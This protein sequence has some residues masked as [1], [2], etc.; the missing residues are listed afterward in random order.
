MKFANLNTITCYSMLNSTIKIPDLVQTAKNRGYSSLAIT[1]YNV[2]HGAIQFYDQCLANDLKPII[3]MTLQTK[4]FKG[5]DVSVVLLAQNQ[6]GY[7][8]L[9]KISTLIN[10]EQIGFDLTKFK[11][12]IAGITAIIH[13]LEN[14]IFQNN[15]E[16]T[17]AL[18]TKYQ[19]IFSTLYLGYC[20][21]VTTL[22]TLEIYEKIY[23]EQK[24]KIVYLADVRYL[25]AEDAVALKVLRA[26]DEQAI[27]NPADPLLSAPGIQ[28]LK[29]VKEITN[30]KQGDLFEA[31]ANAN[32][33]A[34][35]LNV[36]ITKEKT[37]LPHFKSTLKESNEYLA[38]LV[39]DGLKKIGK[40]QDSHY[41]KRANNELKVIE[42]MGFA[43][44]FL[45]IWDIVNYAN[46]AQIQLGAGRG[47]AAGSLV[48][49]ALGISKVDPI[50]YGLFFER[51]LNPERVNMPDIDLDVPDDKRS[52]IIKYLQKRYGK[53]N[54]SQIIVFSTLGVKR[55]LRDCLKI[56]SADNQTVTRWINA[57]PR[58][59]H[60]TLE[61]CY[62]ESAEFRKLVSAD[63]FGRMLWGILK[64]IEGL[65]RQPSIHAAGVVISEEKLVNKI[66]LEDNG[67]DVLITQYVYHDVEELGLLK[68]DILGLRNLSIL[69]KMVDLVRR[70]DDPN[71]Q[72]EAIN[73]HDPASLKIFHD[74]DTDGVFQFE[75]SG[76]KR[77]L[78]NM[79]VEN[80]NDIVAANAL[81]RPGPMGQIN[82]YIEH[83]L[84]KTENTDPDLLPLNSITESTYGVIVYQEQVMQIA[85][86]MA[87]F[88]LSEADMLRRAMSKK[89]RPLLEKYQAKFISGAVNRGY[90]AEQAKKV[91]DL[92]EYF[93]NYGFNKSHSVAYSMLAFWLAYIKAHFPLHF[94]AIQMGTALGDF[95][96][97]RNFIN[98]ARKRSLEVI[99]PNVNTSF[100][101]FTDDGEKIVSGLIIIKGLRRDFIT[102]IVNKRLKYGKYQDFNDL[103]S[104]MDH[105]FLSEDNFIPLIKAGAC[106]D[107]HSNRRELTENLKTNLDSLKFSQNNV[108]LF[109]QLKPRW[110][111]YPDFSND[112]KIEMEHDLTGLYLHGSPFD[113]FQK[114]SQIYHAQ[115][116]QS[117]KNGKDCWIFASILKVRT[118]KDK[119]GKQMAFLTLDDTENQIDSVVFSDRYFELRNQIVEGQKSALYGQTRER[120][121]G[122]NF[123]ISQIFSLN[124]AKKKFD[125]NKLF[126]DISNISNPD[127]QLLQKLL[128][129][130]HGLSPVY[131]IDNTHQKNVL[132]APNSWVDVNEEFYESLLKLVGKEHFVYRD[133]KLN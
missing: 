110:D 58:H 14:E 130:H 3:G 4:G 89:N 96:R 74:G 91:Y 60:V 6:I 59:L 34:E 61:Q 33:L 71:F 114:L 27:L 117:L 7:H 99:G 48:S 43:D 78:I 82:T 79:D 81:F 47:S 8:N 63:S 46:S 68:I 92:I 83:K 62:E 101:N 31:I 103:L 10:S 93:S 125:E 2:L 90:S 112:E 24:I 41:L 121:K 55:S 49:Y 127:L 40:D 52:D 85:N 105:Q 21:A 116:I 9:L 1:D 66:P 102:E 30:S 72:V 119:T 29:S 76:L 122:L 94:F 36:T 22:S 107:L 84:K 42:K 124:E 11:D 131:L 26:I 133:R 70:Y 28:E 5:S 32:S 19:E 129:K 50:K 65:P 109:A 12:F 86:V 25:N 44:Y 38:K 115:S 64:K 77:V 104:R 20:P 100:F 80:F 56:F 120:T 123:V 45:I 37:E 54:F 126:I 16:E 69:K 57:V 111:E 98:A 97:L 108:N 39:S 35:E 118:I 88:P 113:E 106:D 128:K 15:I 17:E 75:S 23:Q 73:E 13:P 67:S 87:G 53:E 132:L 95:D 51:F 18:L